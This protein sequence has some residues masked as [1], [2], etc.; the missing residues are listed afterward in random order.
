MS[1]RPRCATGLAYPPAQ[2]ALAMDKETTLRDL[3]EALNAGDA[4]RA[5]ASLTDDCTFHILP[6]P[7]I[8]APG[9]VRGRVACEEFMREVVSTTGVQQKIEELALNGDF[10]AVFVRSTNTDDSGAEQEVRWA[11]LIRFEGDKI[12]EYVGLST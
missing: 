2:E 11:D 1:E 12:A 9:T 6:N 3:Y 7:L 4:A 8:E 5:A 10:A